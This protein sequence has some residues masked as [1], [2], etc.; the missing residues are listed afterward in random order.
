MASNFPKPTAF[1]IAEAVTQ[2]LKIPAIEIDPRFNFVR[3]AYIYASDID[4][5]DTALKSW[6]EPLEQARNHVIIPSIFKNFESEGRPRWA[7]L[8]KKTIQDRLRLGF[9]RGPILTRTYRLRKAAVQKNIWEVVSTPG[10]NTTDMLRMR[11]E[12]FDQ[13]VPYGQF[14]QLG[15]RLPEVRNIRSLRGFISQSGSSSEFRETTR[16]ELFPTTGGKL[17]ARPFIQLT[18]ADEVEIYGVFFNY[19]SRQVDKHWGSDSEGLG[20]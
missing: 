8:Q 15:A 17:P 18:T 5:L 3:G 13:L 19:L 11:T 12:Y 20:F 16:Q 4:K 7:P 2:G 14:H 6:R 10:S 1:I 9:Q